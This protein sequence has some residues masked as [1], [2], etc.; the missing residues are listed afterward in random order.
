MR[1][2]NRLMLWIACAL[3]ALV[4]VP[5][6]VPAQT[7]PATSCFGYPGAG[8][9][10]AG[11]VW[12]SFLPQGYG[13]NYGEATTYAT[14]GTRRFIHMG[15]FDRGWTTPAT[16]WPIAFPITP[17][18]LKDNW[19]LVFDPDTNWNRGPS[20]SNPSFYSETELYPGARYNCAAELTYKS[21]LN[22]ATDGGRHYSVEPYFVDG[23][24]RQHVVYE[25]AWP[26]QLGVD[27]KLRAH[28]IAAPN[29]N[30][31]NDYVIVEI[32]LKNTGY[33]D[34][35]MD[36]VAEQVNHDIKAL[37]F[38]IEEQAYM[39]ISSYAGGGRN[40]NDIVPTIVARQA[41][42]VN[43][44]DQNGAPWAFSMVFPSAT[45]YN[46]TPGSG[47]TDFGFNGGGTK[48]YMDIHHG[49]VMLDV[50]QGGLPADRS[51]NTS[52]SPSKQTLFGTH[53]I[54]LG[55]ERGWY[56]S[57][58]SN[59]WV[60][61]SGAPAKSFFATT[62]V[63]YQN[64]GILSH[65]TTWGNL[66]LAPNSN[67]FSGGTTA[68]PLTF[69]PKGA[70]YTRPNGDFKSTNTFDQ[71]SFEDGKADATTNYPTGWG[72]WS[73]GCAH[74][75]NFDDDMFSGVGP[76]SLNNGET[77]TIV[78]ATVAG[79]RLEG[80]ERAVRAARFAYQNN[81]N[82]PKPPPLPDVK[83]S[84]TLKKSI[85][86]EWTK[87]A[88]NDAEFAG[89]KIWK[90]S[91][92]K[93]INWLDEGMRVVDQYEQQMAVGARPASVYKPVNPKFDAQA[94]M[95]A[96][97]TKGTYQ[98]DTWGT[99]DLI[100]VIPKANVASLPAAPT[101][102]FNYVYED[103]DVLVGFQYWYYV[104]AYKEGTY[105][106][107][108]G[109]TTTRIETH[110]TNRNGASGLWS[111][112]FPFGYNNA[113]YALATKLGGRQILTS[114]LAPKGDVS[115]VVVVPNPYKRY[116]LFDNR[117]QVYE[118]KVGFLNLPPLAKIT[119][120]DVSG[121][122]IDQINFASNDP[123]NGSY[124][125]D[126]FSKDGI[127]VASGVYLFVVESPTGIQVGQFAILR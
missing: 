2:N 120:L 90:S 5:T 65:N 21:T 113:N 53:P 107:P 105:T 8:V 37:A 60:G 125:W 23:T 7:A 71:V 121:Q 67:F 84:N 93:K 114:A 81:F 95:L 112:T 48:N 63:W 80:I 30:N 108:D 57:G 74:T 87:V 72:K 16:H 104:S 97:A 91:Q 47:N 15:N 66:N 12:E 77:I 20:S 88:E 83:V 45:T 3:L 36:G 34:V 96:N 70:G 49:W 64:G 68:N 86:I 24:L 14:L 119:I 32:E 10:S 13:P 59:Y 31:L 61:S 124:F 76:F 6:S 54:G 111:L 79:Y 58:G 109:E 27:V 100:A 39:S 73:T 69:V 127:E 102:G 35:N 41:G 50:K 75:E 44:A 122:V 103:K 43:D 99:W 92:Y 56:T 22:G 19:V 94:K 51:K 11:D 115:K 85:N 98:P 52:T 62:G 78:Y 33:L 46:P 42:Y 28:G 1:M 55:A 40:V 82:I 110:S 25:A 116:A 118:H 126:M 123:S 9:I 101:S 26:T 4:I 29:W 18:W 38:Q 106:G 17:Y 117:S 89:Y